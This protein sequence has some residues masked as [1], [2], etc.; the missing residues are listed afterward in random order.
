MPSPP[1]HEPRPGVWRRS[2]YD[3]VGLFLFAVAIHVPY[4]CRRPFFFADDF[5]LL[6]D[7]DNL[8]AGATGFFDVPAWGVWRLGERGL[9]WLEYLAFGLKPTPYAVVSVLLH[10][11]VVVS[12]AILLRQ[13]DWPRWSAN[14]AAAVF[15]S[16]SV[17]SLAI[18]Y[19]VQ[20][21][22][23]VC[24]LCV[25]VA[26]IAH[27][28]GKTAVA[29]AI[30]LIGAIFYEQ[31]ICAPLAMA[32]VNLARG[33]RITSKLTIPCAAVAIFLVVNLWTLRHATKVF[34]YNT[35]G[36]DAVRQIVFA[37]WRAAG[38]PPAWTM[39]P[40]IATALLLITVG[41]LA[42]GVLWKPARGILLGM[43]LAWIAS[44][45]YV[46]RN[47]PWWIEYYFYLSGVGVAAAVAAPRLKYW[48][49]VCLPL[50][51]WN[52]K[53]QVPRAAWILTE[54][55]RYEE[56][57]RNTPVQT[58][59]PSAVFVN[60]N[61]GLAWAGWQFGGS[62]EAFE[63]WDASGAPARCYTGQTLEQAREKMQQDFPH[64]IRRGR[65]PEDRPPSLRSARPPAR[66]RL[67]PWPEA[68]KP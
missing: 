38:A 55:R 22:V 17:P 50:V 15:A 18:R 60:V 42:A 34:A 37:P 61:S 21:A 4:L 28:R 49:L 12:V 62:L 26:L 11:G 48:P 8:S 68:A 56:V 51:A 5:G 30:V 23:L 53:A 16:L 65:W 33:R 9:W 44:L 57:T 39:R 36:W 63:L 6:A 24:A 35:A 46:G 64:A 14:T 52:L 58:G 20:S 59:I 32:A 10:A 40:P 13:L 54:M 27:D 1:A 3:L 19:M 25:L 66:R 45:P 47:A 41:I 43:A 31:A 7:A 2:G 29:A 67:F